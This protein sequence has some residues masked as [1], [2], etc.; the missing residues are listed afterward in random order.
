MLDQFAAASAFGRAFFQMVLGA[1]LD[2]SVVTPTGVLRPQ[3]TITI[4]TEKFLTAWTAYMA[5]R[6]QEPRGDDLLPPFTRGSE[7]RVPPDEIADP[8]EGSD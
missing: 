4:E 7:I 3:P 8:P 2:L 6:E 1:D 5:W